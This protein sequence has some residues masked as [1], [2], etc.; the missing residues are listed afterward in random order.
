MGAAE[1]P[2]R[3]SARRQPSRGC[4]SQRNQRRRRRH[5]PPARLR[6]RA[7]QMARRHHAPRR[8]GHGLASTAGQLSFS[9][10]ASAAEI[11][12]GDLGVD[13]VLECTGKFLTPETLEGHLQRGAK[14]VIVA[15]PVKTGGILNIVVGINHQRLRSRQRPHR[16]RRL[17]HHQLPRAGGESGARTSGHPP[18]PDHHHP[19]PHQHQPGGGCN[20]HKDLRRAR[21]AA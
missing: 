3:R 11:P 15:A 8:T 4:S 6:Q 18:R 10:H 2:V 9:S 19:R 20:P 14:R 17:L 21:S 5:R 13:L 12:W 16:H 7:G 1:R